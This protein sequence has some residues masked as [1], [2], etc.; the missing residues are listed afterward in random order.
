MRR[1]PDRTTSGKTTRCCP[2]RIVGG[3]PRF[4]RSWTRRSVPSRGPRPSQAHRRK[5]NA[6]LRTTSSSPLRLIRQRGSMTSAK[7]KPARRN[8]P[9]LQRP[10]RTLRLHPLRC[11]TP[12]SRL[13]PLGRRVRTFRHHLLRRRAPTSRLHRLRRPARPFRLRANSRRS[14]RT[15]FAARERCRTPLREMYL[16]LRLCAR[17]RRKNLK[18][19]STATLRPL[20]PALASIGGGG[21]ETPVPG[22]CSASS[23]WAA[24]SARS[25]P[26]S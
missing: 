25:S 12:T 20:H 7:P 14:R 18:L 11:R 21:V 10:D 2:R 6:A 5:R 9:W 8:L 22:R 13:H 24:P 15:I 19:Q 3:S 17:R 4:T 23:S 16:P 1:A 26:A